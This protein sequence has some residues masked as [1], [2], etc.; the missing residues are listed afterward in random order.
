M[1][2][3]RCY[4]N[5]QLHYITLHYIVCCLDIKQEPTESA[6]T[7][8]DVCGRDDLLSADEKLADACTGSPLGTGRSQGL[9]QKVT[10]SNMCSLNS[11]VRSSRLRPTSNK[12]STTLT[13]PTSS[14]TLT[15]LIR[16]TSSKTS[17]TLIPSPV[18]GEKNSLKGKGQERNSYTAVEVGK[19][20][21]KRKKQVA[22]SP[23]TLENG[24]KV[25]LRNRKVRSGKAKNLS[26]ETPIAIKDES[27]SSADIR[28]LDGPD[29][30][31]KDTV[32]DIVKDEAEPNDGDDETVFSR[33]PLKMRVKL[34][35]KRWKSSE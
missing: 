4:I 2:V 1:V 26:S 28:L 20:K 6:W 15:T 3:K 9:Q 27:P 21:V 7:I 22:K 12:T 14:K 34:A 29:S 30:A 33:I 23:K 19:P 11:L 31:K 16:S 35:K 18:N 5:C 17:T 32:E 24:S 8:L 13:R 25:G 10:K